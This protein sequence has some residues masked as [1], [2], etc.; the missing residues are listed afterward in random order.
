MLLLAGGS[1]LVYLRAL[2]GK[3]KNP[4][5]GGAK[6]GAA[7]SG[8]TGTSGRYSKKQLT[9]ASVRWQRVHI[10]STKCM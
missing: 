5:P 9:R 2:L 4:G 7:L 10:A 3:K 6:K 1:G 8:V